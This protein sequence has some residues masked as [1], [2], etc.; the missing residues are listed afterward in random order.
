MF[1]CLLLSEDHFPAGINRVDT[2]YFKLL[3]LTLWH[4]A[5]LTGVG[6]LVPN[7]TFMD[8]NTLVHPL[9]LTHG[10]HDSKRNI[11]GFKALKPQIFP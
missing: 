7:L 5:T 3:A 4:N 2:V 11:C 10:E 9:H 6:Y 1:A 8:S